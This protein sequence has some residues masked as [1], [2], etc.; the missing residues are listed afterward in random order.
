MRLQN[1]IHL[2]SR[3]QTE[4][5]TRLECRQLS[6]PDALGGKRLERSTSESRGVVGKT[7]GE[8]LTGH[9]LMYGDDSIRIKLAGGA[10]ERAA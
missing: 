5:G 10:V 8:F 3:L 7:A 1:A 9:A 2:A 6:G 4:K